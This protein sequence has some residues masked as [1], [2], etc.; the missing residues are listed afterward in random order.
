MFA[1][2]RSRRCGRACLCLGGR[3][4]FTLAEG[5]PAPEGLPADL[6]Q[7]MVGGPNVTV[8]AAAVAVDADLS[9]CYCRWRFA[10]KQ[11]QLK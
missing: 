2:R 6:D 10:V 1:P 3:K 9:G 11:E 4:K 5:L 7:L 8:V